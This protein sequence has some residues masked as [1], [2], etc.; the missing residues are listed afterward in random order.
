MREESATPDSRAAK[1][2]GSQHGVIAADQLIGAGMSA[3][4]VSRRVAAGRLH[5]VHRGVYAIGHAGISLRGR[6]M[7]AVLAC[8]EPARRNRGMEG[9]TVE[10]N[11]GD[12]ATKGGAGDVAVAGTTTVLTRW[13][14]ALSHRSAACLWGLL[15]QGEGAVDVSVRGDGGRARRRGVR[16]H[17]SV[18]LLPVDVTLREGIPV[19]TPARTIADLRR[20]AAGHRG[21]GRIS[22]RELRQAIREA[23]VLGLPL[24]ESAEGDRTRSEL[25]RAFLRLC[26]RHRLPPPEVNVR[27]GPYLVDFLWRDRRLVV[28]TDGYRYHRGRAAFEGDRGR[29]LDLRARGYDVIRLA[30]GQLRDDARRVADILRR[31]IRER[32]PETG[33]DR[34][35]ADRA[36]P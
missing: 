15:A 21:R 29:D 33:A 17:R 23:E 18:S 30:E 2:A 32:V 6:W 3:S 5:R 1:I 28:E 14:A 16:L 13:G 10:E 24:G 22:Q 4:A 36:A 26:R 11:A 35:R 9:A 25:E 19:T 31:A 20:A 7:A 8:G 27:I 34:D 12:L